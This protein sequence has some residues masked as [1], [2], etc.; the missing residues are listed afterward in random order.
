VPVRLPLI[1]VTMVAA[2][3]A[4]KSFVIDPLTRHFGGSFEDFSPYLG[5]ARSVAAGISPYASFHAT[6]V[7]LSGFDYPP[8]AAVVLRPFAFFS[9]HGAMVAWIIVMLVLT[10]AGG[11]VLARAALPRGWPA[12]ALGILAGLVFA[13]SAYNL[14][15]GQINPL[16]FFL[17]VIGYWAYGR[18]RPVSCGVALGLAA[19]IKIAPLVLIVL[20]I[21][22]RWWRATAAMLVTGAATIGV[23][24]SL[25]V[26]VSITF[27]TH[28]FPDLNRA[29][30][31]VYDQSLTGTIS[32]VA[33]QSVLTVAPTSLAVQILGPLSSLLVIGLAAWVVRPARRAAS[34]RGLEY[35][36]GV[37]SMLLAGGLTWYPQFTHLLIPLFAG[38]GW[39]GERGWRKERRVVVPWLAVI[40]VFGLLAP[41]VIS[42]LTTQWL[43]SVRSTPAW[44]PLLQLFSLPC[45]TMVWLAA[46]IA[47]RLHHEVLKEANRA[48]RSMPTGN[49]GRSSGP[50]MILHPELGTPSPGSAS[51][52]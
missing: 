14:W 8:F 2:L 27:L 29:T 49:G 30:G 51:I 41:A 23:G 40:G 4:M 26:G 9:D 36:L 18:D 31:W 44:W 42:V 50:L 5:A 34:V 43:A 12:T 32:R 25:G 39:V 47:R 17:L 15:H 38:L 24:L 10:L 19:G 7:V 6:T 35:G 16:I 22:R 33:D 28:V 48:G 3:A 45:A 46:A 11:V 20:L 21:R 37:T 52:V 13:P 1:L